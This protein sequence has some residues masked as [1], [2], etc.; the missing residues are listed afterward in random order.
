MCFDKRKELVAP[1]GIP[2]SRILRQAVKLGGW[3]DHSIIDKWNCFYSDTEDRIFCKT[4]WGWEIFVHS[5]RG[6]Y[7][8]W[9]FTSETRPTSATKMI[10]LSHRNTLVIPERSST[11]STVQQDLNLN[12]Y[13]PLDKLSPSINPLFLELLQ[14][15]RALLDKYVLPPNDGAAIAHAMALTTIQ[16]KLD[17]LL[18]S[19]LLTKIRALSA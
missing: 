18:W 13:N 10:T 19:L 15:P 5:T 9:A 16:G 1:F 8:L 4:K 11:W 14:T 12:E 7:C 3:S 17:L 2:T 6:K